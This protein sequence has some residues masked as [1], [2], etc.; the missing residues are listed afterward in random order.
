MLPLWLDYQ[1]PDPAR[2]RPGLLLL[3]VGLLAAT[4]LLGRYFAVVADLD[5]VG[6]Q[7]SRL[8]RAAARQL[9]VE[10]PAGSGAAGAVAPSA[11][12]WEALFAALEAAGDES[13]TLLSLQPGGT[14][15]LIAG[16][17]MNLGAAMEYVKRLQSA[18]VLADVHLTQS[19]VVPEHPQRPVRFALAS[20]W[21][22]AAP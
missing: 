18:A 1:R 9:P 8:K 21:R 20:A 12:R 14:E 6:Q 16:E 7:V 2:H 15:I 11:A 19:E 5:E 13:V 17:A 3:G 4:V 22:E 10:A